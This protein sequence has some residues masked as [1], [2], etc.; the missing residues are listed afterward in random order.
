MKE[1][2]NFQKLKSLSEIKEIKVAF[3][4]EDEK[5]IKKGSDG[6]PLQITLKIVEGSKII[7][8]GIGYTVLGESGDKPLIT[9]EPSIL[10][11]GSVQTWVK[12]I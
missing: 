5:H 1:I 9:S 2:Q 11:K 7:I 12:R 3:L 8:D 4:P 6:N 10:N